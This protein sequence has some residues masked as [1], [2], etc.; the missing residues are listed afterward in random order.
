MPRQSRIDAP[1]ACIISSSAEL[2]GAISS[3]RIRIVTI[4]R[5]QRFRRTGANASPGNLSTQ[6]SPAQAKGVDENA[7]ARRVADLLEIDIKLCSVARQESLD[8]EGLQPLLTRRF[9]ATA[10]LS[11]SYHVSQR[12]W[13]HGVELHHGTHVLAAPLTGDLSA[14]DMR[15]M[16][17][18]GSHV[19]LMDQGV[20]QSL[21]LYDPAAPANINP[22]GYLT[23]DG[24]ANIPGWKLKSVIMSGQGGEYRVKN[25]W[26]FISPDVWTGSQIDPGAVAFGGSPIDAVIGSNLFMQTTLSYDGPDDTLGIGVKSSG[27]PRPPKN[28]HVVS[29]Q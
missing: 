10:P 24:A 16:Y 1:G 13:M 20:A 17:D 22:D 19:S 29:A 26:F 28:L 5:G 8:C 27:A 11:G 3:V 7:V 6:T 21:G 25:A 14:I 23:I 18:T 9:G 15:F 12:L 4:F 2:G